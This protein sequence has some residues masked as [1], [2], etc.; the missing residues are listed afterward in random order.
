VVLVLTPVVEQVLAQAPDMG[1]LDFGDRHRPE[2]GSQMPAEQ[3][4][5]KLDRLGSQ[6][7]THTREVDTAGMSAERQARYLIDL[8]AARSMRRQIGEAIHDLQEAEKIAPELT[9]PQRRAPDVMRDLL[10]LSGLRPRPELRDRNERS[11]HPHPDAQPGR[12]R[13]I[14]LQ[15][16]RSSCGDRWHLV[17]LTGCSLYILSVEEVAMAKTLIDVDEQY[18]AA[19]REVLHTET[20]KDT[21]NAALRE[22]AAMAARRRDLRRLASGGLPDLEDEEVMRGA[23][24]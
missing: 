13:R 5:V 11:Q 20:K 16:T 19:A 22:V 17:Y 4:A 23:W 1:R 8:A 15:A 10:Q 9:R 7:G 3:V 6:A 2:D 14:T 24:Q 18:L 12:E 21:V